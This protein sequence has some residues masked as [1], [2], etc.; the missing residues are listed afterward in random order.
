[1]NEEL[2]K[3]I[4]EFKTNFRSAPYTYTRQGGVV[5]GVLNTHSLIFTNK[6]ED[7]EHVDDML[8]VYRDAM[9]YFFDVFGF[10][11]NTLGQEHV[12]AEI[13]R[14]FNGKSSLSGFLEVHDPEKKLEYQSALVEM[15]FIQDPEYRGVELMVAVVAMI[16]KPGNDE[17]E[18]V[19][20]LEILEIK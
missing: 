10:K 15:R 3:F 19:K 13:K 8:E 11:N 1:M 17:Y 7:Q 18:V 16:L 9:P 2:Q 14:I 12:L 4:N 5:E 20:S 6:E